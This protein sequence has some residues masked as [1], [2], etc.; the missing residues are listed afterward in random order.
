MPP[1]PEQLQFYPWQGTIIPWSAALRSLPSKQLRTLA[2]LP[3]GTNVK[4][5]QKT[6]GWLLVEGRLADGKTFKGYVSG[7]L[8]KSTP[9]VNTTRGQPSQSN[10]PPYPGATSN[11]PTGYGPNFPNGNW[12]ANLL[13]Q[14][15][16]ANMRVAGYIQPAK[17]LAQQVLNDVESGKLTHMEG[18]FKAYTQRNE[19]LEQIRKRLSPGGRELSRA[20]KEEGRALSDLVSKYAHKVLEKSPDL[21]KKYGLKTLDRSSPAFNVSLYQRAIQELGS[22]E[23]V[24]KEIIA[25]AGRSDKYI[26]AMARFTRYAG[27]VGMAASLGWSG[28]EVVSAPKDQ[29]L[30]VAG[31]EASGFVGGLIGSVGG[32]LV[33][34]W[35][36]SLL[37]GPG[38]PVCALIVSLVVVGTSAGAV[39]FGFEKGYERLM[40]R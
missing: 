9:T 1:Q 10:F 30:Y 20:I 39:G 21:M 34:G 23:L 7:E 29:G 40:G 18:R 33:G 25:A 27:P 6:Q 12:T 3:F 11:T 2:D 31:R 19:L 14:S 22:S 13:I 38:A 32:G 17:A 4:V 8:I 28:Y 26:S 35:A 37:C 5:I 16:D 24:S 15:Y 36:A